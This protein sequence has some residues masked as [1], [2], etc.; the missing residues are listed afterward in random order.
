MFYLEAINVLNI[1]N[2]FLITGVTPAGVTEVIFLDIRIRAITWSGRRSRVISGGGRWYLDGGEFVRGGRVVGSGGVSYDALSGSF[3]SELIFRLILPFTESRLT[4]LTSKP[5][6]P[7]AP[8]QRFVRL[9]ISH[10][11]PPI[12]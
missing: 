11:S 2:C 5:A 12:A 9:S 6:R 10:R 8:V 7:A 3:T 4:T 1:K